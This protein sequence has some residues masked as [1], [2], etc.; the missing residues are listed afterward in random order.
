MS[1]EKE[2]LNEET[3]SEEN[4]VETTEAKTDENTVI[5]AEGRGKKVIKWIA[6]GAAAVAI[7]VVGALTGH[8]MGGKDE[9]DDNSNDDAGETE[10][11]E[12]N[13]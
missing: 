2:N 3:M 5:E 12:E 9:E 13:N 11:T 6:R 4:V 8:F 7:F 1:K 10:T